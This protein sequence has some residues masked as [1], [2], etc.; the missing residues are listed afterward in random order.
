MKKK[1]Q[2]F[3]VFNT[4]QPPMSVHKQFQLYA[5]YIYIYIYIQTNVFFLLYIDYYKKFPG[6]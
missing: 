4:P 6:F 2:I 1:F 3:L 5:T